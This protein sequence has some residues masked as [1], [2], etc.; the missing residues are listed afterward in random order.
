MRNGR[1]GVGLVGC[2]SQGPR[3]ARDLGLYDHLDL[4]GVADLDL[5]RAEHLAARHG[6]KA[7]RSLEDMLQDDAIDIV[8]DVTSPHTHKEIVSRC[9]EADKHVFNEK[10]LALTYQDARDLVELAEEHH[11]LLG[12]A[13]ATYLGEA[14]QTAMKSIRDGRLGRVRVVY[15]EANWGRIESWHPSP[16]PFYTV[17]PLFDVG[18]YPLTIVTAVL[19]PAARVSAFGKVVMPERATNRGVRFEVETPDFVVASIELAGGAVVRLSANFYVGQ[20]SKQKGLEFHGDEASLYL[21]SFHVFDC[22]VEYSRFDDA[23]RPL[24][25]VADPFEGTDWARGV[26]DMGNAILEDRPHQAAG[27]H[28]AHVIE[29]LCAISQSARAA[30][31]VDVTSSF[32]PPAPLPWSG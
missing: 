12:S 32:V 11:R 3:Y 20:H 29:I 15:C 21:E 2:G 7:Y 16:I 18:L 6:V 10:P 4:L 14:Q 22:G 19:G 9:L 31:A 8:V 26:A 28:A 17:G 13:P 27:D 25:L 1:L 23:Y 24:D 30:E 5:A